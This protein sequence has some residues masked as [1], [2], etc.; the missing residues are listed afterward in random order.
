M[1]NL[2]P[3]IQRTY[4]VLGLFA[5][6]LYLPGCWWGL[7]H[8][9]AGDRKQSWAVDGAA[10]TG[11]IVQV[12]SIVKPRPGRG[13]GYP[14]MHSF[15]LTSA[16]VPYLA[17]LF[18]TGD[19]AEIS[20]RFPYGLVDPVGSLKILGLIANLVSVMM[21]VGIVVA[22]YDSAR[23]LWDRRT[24]ILAALFTAVSFPMFYYSRTSNVDVATLFF[25]A[26]ALA[27]F[28]RCLT[29]GI[30]A[31]RMAW[32][33][34]FTGF[35]LAT[36]EPSFASF[37]ALPVV[38]LVLHRRN[39]SPPAGR[40]WW[41]FWKIPLIGLL[42]C[43]L[44]FGAGSGLF[45]DPAHYFAHVE[46]A[47]E[48]LGATTAGEVIFQETFPHT[49]D[50]HLRLAERTL[51][52]LVDAMTLPGLLLAC[53]GMLWTLRRERLTFAFALP[54]FTYL[55]VLFWAAHAAQLRYVMPAVF[56]LTFFEARAV[57][58]AWKSARS[59]VR[60]SLALLALWIV[61]VSLLRGADLT[62]AML[63]DSRYAAADWL[64]QRTQPGDS[65]EAFGWFPPLPPLKAGVSITDP[66][67]FLPAETRLGPAEEAMRTR[68]IAE[69]LRKAR[70]QLIIV[71]PDYTSPKGAVYS[72]FCPPK[73]Y[74]SLLDGTL[75]YR[76]A[77]F[78]QTPPLLPWV[79]RPAL[80]YPTVN[81][82]IHIFV[83]AEGD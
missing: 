28:A 36:K 18:L 29:G 44:A 76:L 9:T 77:A 38:L 1:R 61:G 20:T 14:M 79:R 82:P 41:E 23:T 64:D 78:F 39:F 62:H 73:I 54:A 63:N 47:T 60:S 37:V 74:E 83:P 22:V 49:W 48:R 55:A 16:Y 31:R 65:V 81:P 51:G 70:P 15:V 13:L 26:L 24:G 21:A 19:F 69:G 58:V 68:K 33:G 46:F 66:T 12:L 10:P 4:L 32:M 75:G 43:F 2:L 59:A 7:P 45:V 52:Y 50:G 67:R 27:A 72:A 57:S 5:L 30:T 6:V 25:T 71:M 34:I 17:Y 56:T 42:A 80:D 40:Q 3:R 8:A 35:A 11:P 53:G